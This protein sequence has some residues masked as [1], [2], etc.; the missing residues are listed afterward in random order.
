[1]CHLDQLPMPSH[2]QLQ[3]TSCSSPGRTTGAIAMHLALGLIAFKVNEKYEHTHY[4]GV[5]LNICDALI[6]YRVEFVF[7]R[8]ERL[9]AVMIDPRNHRF[10]F[11][12]HSMRRKSNVNRNT[13]QRSRSLEFSRVRCCLRQNRACPPVPR[14][15]CEFKTAISCRIYLQK[16]DFITLALRH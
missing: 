14:S 8:F 13:Y 9:V 5:A 15:L 4:I 1:M 12:R 11:V 10:D 7:N 3:R 16:I 6:L 2:P